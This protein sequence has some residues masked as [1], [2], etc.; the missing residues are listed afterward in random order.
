[1]DANGI[2][3]VQ[4]GVA[5]TAAELAAGAANLADQA[6][7]VITPPLLRLRTAEGTAWCTA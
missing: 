2:V 5:N 7:E 3:Q 6:A 1:M 4:E